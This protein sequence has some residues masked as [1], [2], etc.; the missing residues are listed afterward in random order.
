VPKKRG[1]TWTFP[2]GVTCVAR[3]Y[4]TL[5]RMTLTY[6]GGK[7]IEWVIR[8]PRKSKKGKE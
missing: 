5:V 8:Y 1:T 7:P 2:D 4:K 3:C 6:Q